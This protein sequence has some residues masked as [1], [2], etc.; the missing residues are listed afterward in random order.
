M[1]LVALVHPEETLTVPALQAKNKCTL[2][3]Q[4]EA[5]LAS[6]YKLRSSVSLT[7]FRQFV[8]ALEGNAIE[9]ASADFSGLTQLCE[10]FGFEELRAKLSKF[11]PP[12]GTAAEAAARTA[13]AEERPGQ[14]HREAAAIELRLANE[15]VRLPAVVLCQTCTAFQANPMLPHYSVTSAV[16]SEIFQTFLSAVKGQ[17][18]EVTPANFAGLSAL[19]GEFGFQLSSPSYRLCTLEAELQSQRA[20]IGRLAGEVAALRGTAAQLSAEVAELRG[21]TAAAP[22]S[23]ILSGLH[24]QRTDSLIVSDFPGI[25]AEFRGKQFKLLWRGSRDGFGASQFHGRCDAHSNTLTVILDTEGN[26]F[27]GFTPLEWESRVWN[28]KRGRKTIERRWMTARR[29]S[30]S[31]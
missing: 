12:P 14:L 7:L 23:L 26:I 28:G 21:W 9:I 15:R 16:S 19:C 2:F 10:E 24:A 30:F 27:G 3:Q 18:I 22:E 29:V 13:A 31:R 17:S 1:A 8:S 25:F 4:N 5:L 11:P 6:P 20:D